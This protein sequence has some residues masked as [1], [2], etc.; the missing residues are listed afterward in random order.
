M[1][2]KRLWSFLFCL[3][4][5]LSFAGVC[6]A[7]EDAQ[8]AQDTKS[9]DGAG[10]YMDDSVITASVK[11]DMVKD[12]ITKA[13]DISVTTNMGV[14]QLTG[15]AYTKEEKARA[16]EIARSVKG[17]ADVKNDIVVQPEEVK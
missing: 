15:R 8:G 12:P 17:V 5:V 9:K 7:A 3:M 14:V 13:R 16:E 2:A 6:A 1:T 4:L 10:Q 11:A